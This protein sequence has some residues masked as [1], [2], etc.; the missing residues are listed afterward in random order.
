MSS[1]TKI[2]IIVLC[3]S[4]CAGGA[5]ISVGGTPGDD[6]T[7]TKVVPVNNPQPKRVICIWA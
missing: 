6:C 3:L 5:L 7:K 2:L 1:A 4:V